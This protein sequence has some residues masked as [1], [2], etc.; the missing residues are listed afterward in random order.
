MHLHLLC[1]IWHHRGHCNVGNRCDWANQPKGQQY[2]SIYLSSHWLLH[3]VGEGPYV[4]KKTFF[5]GALLLTRMDGDDL[6][7]P[8]NSDSVKKYCVW[9]VSSNQINEALARKFSLHIPHQ[10]AHSWYQ[11]LNNLIFQ[12]FFTRE[13]ILLKWGFKRTDFVCDFNEINQLFVWN[14]VQS[15]SLER[16]DQTSQKHAIG[17]TITQI[18][19]WIHILSAWIMVGSTLVCHG[20]TKC[21]I[22]QIQSI[23]LDVDKVYWF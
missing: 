10:K 19:S 9:C 23:T 20:L 11:L 5:G 3:K 14:N 22:L 8:V 15:N 18:I 4:V 13:Y 17:T 16:D 1:L 6:P 21:G 12:T 7:R 2:A